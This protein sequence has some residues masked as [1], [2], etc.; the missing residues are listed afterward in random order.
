MRKI[1]FVMLMFWVALVSCGR[2]A[3][4][5]TNSFS[6]E[7]I[8][9]K[10][11]PAPPSITLLEGGFTAETFVSG[12]SDPAGLAFTNPAILFV[13][14]SE[15]RASRGVPEDHLLRILPNGKVKAFVSE[16]NTP[17][18]LTF[19]K[20]RGLFASEFDNGNLLQI[21]SDGSG[22][23]FA[24]GFSRPVDMTFDDSGNLYISDVGGGPNSERIARIDPGGTVTTIIT[25]S[26]A[27]NIDP[28]GLA[29][30]A[31]G[32]LFIAE[33]GPGKITKIPN[34]TS[35]PIDATSMAPFVLV[36]R[37]VGLAFD[38]NGDL[39]VAGRD[40]IFRVTP[41]ATVT[42]FATGLA[43]GFNRI[44]FNKKGDIYFTDMF[45]GTVIKVTKQ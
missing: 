16:L 2:N 7:G 17:I 37:P 32:D 45:A 43:G 25:Y 12:L 3:P 20:G 31:N 6:E 30:N 8:L 10:Q 40:D 4:V 41:S 19:E 23:V 1:A 28:N 39:F 14:E 9:E 18:G 15:F 27:V 34:G 22:S 21:S 29:F 38:Q 24:S 44:T 42:T 35:F 13:N 5:E 36:S 11:A 26:D 33:L